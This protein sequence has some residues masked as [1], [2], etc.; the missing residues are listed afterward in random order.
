MVKT[1]NKDN[2]IKISL[3]GLLQIAPKSYKLKIKILMSNDS[4]RTGF[5][6][7]S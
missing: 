3:K 7:A 6:Q 5:R 1:L 2:K 4:K